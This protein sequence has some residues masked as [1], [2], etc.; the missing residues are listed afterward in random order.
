MR[1]DMNE[2]KRMLA[3]LIREQHGTG[4]YKKDI[5]GYLTPTN[6]YPAVPAVSAA[7][8]EPVYADTEEVTDEPQEMTKERAQREAILKALRHHN[9]RRK[10]AAKELFISERTLYRKIKELGIDEY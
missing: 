2:M 5:A 6:N 3:E 10:E 8:G 7:V 9:G 4:E 1:G